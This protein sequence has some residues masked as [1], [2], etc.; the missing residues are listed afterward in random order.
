[1]FTVCWP[2]QFEMTNFLSFASDFRVGRNL[3][4]AILD[5]YQ[6]MGIIPHEIPN[7]LPLHDL[8][9]R[10]PSNPSYDTKT[11]ASGSQKQVRFSNFIRFKLKAIMPGIVI[12]K[13]KAN[14]WI[15]KNC[16]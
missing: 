5:Y 3:A 15:D 11:S 16:I 8:P 13:Y 12:E 14:I 2:T 7:A 10:Y 6:F 9:K 1:M 4:R